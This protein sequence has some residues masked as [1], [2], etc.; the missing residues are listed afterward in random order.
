MRPFPSKAPAH[1][2]SLTLSRRA[3]LTGGTLTVAFALAGLPTRSLAQ[4]A[5][6]MAPRNVDPREVDSFLAVNADGTIT[7]FCGKVDLG[8][9]LRIAVRQMAA[10]EL[11]LSPDRIVLIEGDT[12]LTPDQ[13]PTAGS[14]G[15][16]RGGVQIRQA[17]ATAR[18]ALLELAAQ[19]LNRSPD[20]LDIADGRVRA[21]AGGKGLSFADILGGKRFDV[22]LD[23]GA[24]LRD[25]KTYRV[26]GQP[27]PRPDIPAKVT[28]AHI[29]MQ[30][31]SLPGMLHGRVIR[32][33]AIG[34]KLLSVDE[35]S[36]ARFSGA[37]L[38]RI[39]DF[40]GVVAEDEW[41]AVR[42]A[43]ALKCRWGEGTGLPPQDALAA[44]MRAGP[45]VREESL[46]AKGDPPPAGAADA[47]SLKANYFWPMQSHA[48]MGPSCA[49]ADMRE[50]TARIWSASQATHRLRHTLAR[51][52]ALPPEKV[53]VTYL[54]GAGCYG[55]NGHDDA[56]A[57]AALLSR[58]VGRPVRVQWMREDEHGFDPKGPPQLIDVAGAV[59]AQG[60]LLDWQTDMFIAEA[61]RGLPN[62][63]LLGPQAAG[64]T[65]TPGLSTGLISQNGDPS[66][67]A[68]RVQV[69][70]HWL[71]DTPLR[72]SNIRAPGKIANCFAVES[73][74][75]E[76]AAAAGQDPAEMRLRLLS[77]PRD[78]AMAAAPVT[79]A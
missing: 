52:F 54:D 75:D 69:R 67:A 38:V 22:K 40:L 41:T 11:G 17:A 66:Y 65:Q 70:V 57:D 28:G 49:V 29:Y 25:P 16:Q 78:D 4:S 35:T 45:F 36:I 56:A 63:P 72:P 20:E 10:E 60:R 32:P 34:A 1:P 2:A 44:S 55:M 23:P 74:F 12:A 62:I 61:T 46:V 48:S 68:G 51:L 6:S 7:L 18:K 14:T 39:N 15:V 42:A 13:G 31:F 73:F 37:K 77:D 33:R 71:K 21:K 58:A 27:L 30:D 26:V 59:D 24:P 3:I 9:G 79:G 5:D 76:L 43:R 53:R 19:L 50:G 8:Q 64:M 47:I